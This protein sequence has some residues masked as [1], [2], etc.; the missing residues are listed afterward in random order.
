MSEFQDAL[1]A[2]WAE[3]DNPELD[4]VNPHFKNR[5]ASL[6]ATLRPIRRACAAH[7]LAYIQRV[8]PCEGGREIASAVVGHG[9]SM[10]LSRFPVG[11]GG[12]PQQTGSALTYAKRQLAQLD[13]GIVGEE[14]D[15][16]EAACAQPAQPSQQAAAPAPRQASAA[17]DAE[18]LTRAKRRLFDACNA[19]EAAACRTGVEAGWAAAGVRNRP[20]YPQPD[21]PAVEQAEWFEMVAVEFE[22]EAAYVRND[23]I[24]GGTA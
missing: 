11:F 1:A 8:V 13:W 22:S 19:Y 9:E 17:T 12:N 4:S 15:D 23:R 16:A 21:A 5:F 6:A 14:D 2:A 24:Q 18:R 7:G 3:C 10:E 20:D